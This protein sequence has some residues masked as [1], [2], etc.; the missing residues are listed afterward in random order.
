MSRICTRTYNVEQAR[1][2]DGHNIINIVMNEQGV[3]LDGA[4][5][6]VAAS[7]EQFLS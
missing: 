5:N 4:I 1:G 6:C 7:Y 2:D 3:D